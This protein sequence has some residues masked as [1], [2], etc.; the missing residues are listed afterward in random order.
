MNTSTMHGPTCVCAAI[1]WLLFLFA[2]AFLNAQNQPPIATDRPAITALSTVA[3]RGGLLIESGFTETRSQGQSGFDFPETLIRLGTTAK[4]ELRF[5]A[6]DYF[7]NFNTGAGFNTGWGDLSL[8]VKQQLIATST[9]FDLALVASLSFPTG[10][11]DISSHGYDPQVLLPWSLPICKD[12]TAAGMFALYWPTVFSPS[13]SSPSVLSPSVLS[14]TQGQAR[15]LTGQATFLLDRQ[16]SKRWD[17]FIEH[18]GT[19]PQHGSPQHLLHVGVAF[20]VT[21]NQQVDF[22]SGFGLSSAAPDHFIGFGYSF[23]LQTLH[24]NKQNGS[25]SCSRCP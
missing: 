7:Y 22:H 2:T 12:W 19:F 13:V 8:G 10:A 4:T 18:A 23:R 14:Q 1:C 6:P 25:Q 9:G 20:K 16:I 21:S 24:C 17:A 11:N 5:A 15:N 3:P